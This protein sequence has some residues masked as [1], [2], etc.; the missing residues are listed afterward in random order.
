MRRPFDWTYTTDTE[1]SNTTERNSGL[2][3]IRGHASEGTR[4]G[5]HEDGRHEEKLSVPSLEPRKRSV[6]EDSA[7]SRG[8][9]WWDTLKTNL[10]RVSLEDILEKD[11][12]EVEK[13]KEV[14]ACNK[15]NTV[16]SSNDGLACEHLMW[17]HWVWSKLPLPDDETEDERNAD[18]EL[19]KDVC[20]GP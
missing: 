19:N 7:E 4:E 1:T 8:Q 20:R 3:D 17:H 14:H 5:G 16:G 12:E 10:Y 9:R 15:C 2:W 13:G 6:G 18:E 11:W